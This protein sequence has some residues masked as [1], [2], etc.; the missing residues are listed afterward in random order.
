MQF[1]VFKMLFYVLEMQLNIF[2]MQ[3]YAPCSVLKYFKSNQIQLVTGK[4]R[5]K[6]IE[7][8]RV[9]QVRS[10]YIELLPEKTS[11]IMSKPVVIQIDF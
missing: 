1:C 6:Y 4:F 3:S 8:F 10:S 11:F 2:K 5:S 9:V 7:K